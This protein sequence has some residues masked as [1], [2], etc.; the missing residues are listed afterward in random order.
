MQS[1]LT[2]TLVVITGKG[3]VGKSTIAA[4]LALLAA[5]R[6]L[7]VIVV[8]MGG[9]QLMP[10]LLGARPQAESGEAELAAGVW[11]TSIDPGTC[12]FRVAGCARREHPRAAA[13]LARHLS[14]LRGRGSRRERAREP[15]QDL[16][17]HP[18]GALAQARRALRPRAG[19][20]AGHRACAR[21]AELAENIRRRSRELDRSRH[22]L[23]RFESCSKTLRA[24]AT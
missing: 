3:G 24:R 2:R 14:V 23:G 8:E 22:R 12:A 1:I 17:A 20:R 15:R 4:A 7:R 5:R 10:E 9:R 19:G 18:G 6:G 21:A 11:S 13:R 16:G